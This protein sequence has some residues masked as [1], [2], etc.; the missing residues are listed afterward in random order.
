MARRYLT[1]AALVLAGCNLPP[2]TTPEQSFAVKYSMFVPDIAQGVPLLTGLPGFADKTAPSSTVPVPKEAKTLKL[3]SLDLNLRMRNTGPLPLRIKLFLGR[4][5][6]TDK[7]LYATSPLGGD[8]GTIDLPRGGNSDVNKVFPIDVG[9]LQEQ[10]LKLGYSFGSP[11]TQDS[12]T[13]KDTDQVDIG[14]SIKAIAK[15]I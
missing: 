1:L 10:N 14:Y 3:A 6:L 15:L 9:L 12:V 13:F 8:Q 11:G 7:E 2:Y 5:A 4:E